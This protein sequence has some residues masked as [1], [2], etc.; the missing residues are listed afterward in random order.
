ML[1]CLGFLA[2][3]C[4]TQN[5]EKL[6]PLANFIGKPIGEARKE[7]GKATSVY[8]MQDGT[9]EYIWRNGVGGGS[10]SGFMGVQVTSS[11]PR[12]CNRVLI[13]NTERVIVDFRYEGRC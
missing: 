6:D 7:L 13:T 4:A 1:L 2:S 9:L 3:S 10:S 11:S 8:D 5:G 12:S